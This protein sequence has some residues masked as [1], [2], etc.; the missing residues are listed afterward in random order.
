MLYQRSV[1][2]A[3]AI[4]ATLVAVTSL[5]INADE[6]QAK[7]EGTV[8]RDA[9]NGTTPASPAEQNQREQETIEIPLSEIWA[10]DMP[11]TRDVRELE[12]EVEAAKERI[13]SL[14][15]E[16]RE[17]QFMR[18]FKNSLIGQIRQSLKLTADKNEGSGFAVSSP[19]PLK[20]AR[21]VLTGETKRTVSFAAGSDIT[22]VFFSRQSNALVQIYHVERRANVIEIRYRFVP[23]EDAYVSEHF[24]LIPLGKLPSRIYQV[25]VLL[26][27]MQQ[28]YL[29]AGVKQITSAQAAKFVSQSFKFEVQR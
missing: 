26:G 28:K 16:Q 1:I 2:V 4:V 8:S 5:S 29:V 9:T 27:P 10:L 18:L 21:D 17:E 13:K 7:S 19:E 6:D 25:K 22:A 24:A 12:P 23:H 15:A 3:F 14:P 11:G 20:A